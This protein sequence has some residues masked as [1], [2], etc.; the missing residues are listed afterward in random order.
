MTIAWLTLI[1]KPECH[2]CDDARAVVTSV[3]SEL[4]DA[5]SVTLEEL[6]ILDDPALAEKY[7]DEIPVLMI[8][9]VVHNIWRI[10]P[11]R[12]RAAIAEATA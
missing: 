7:W 6:S 1:G 3:V 5:A 10:D 4:D 9:S 11:V 8:N 12:L 2:L